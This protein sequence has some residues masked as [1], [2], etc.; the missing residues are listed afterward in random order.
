MNIHS[1][2]HTNRQSEEIDY[3]I[4]ATKIDDSGVY[5]C[6]AANEYGWINRD[7]QVKVIHFPKSVTIPKNEYIVEE[8]QPNVT[9]P[10]L[11][12]P[13][14]YYPFNVSWLFNNATNDT[15]DAVFQ[16]NASTIK[17]FSMEAFCLRLNFYLE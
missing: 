16:V 12:S 13:E 14:P 6:G 3:K 1:H 2:V 11:L 17:S 4:N 8:K 7:I 9:I 10:C 15:N 5:T